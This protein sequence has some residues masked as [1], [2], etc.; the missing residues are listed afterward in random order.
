MK[1]TLLMVVAL[2]FVVTCFAQAA[3]ITFFGEDLNG[4]NFNSQIAHDNF[5]A[6]LSGVGTED[7]EG[8][9]SGTVN[10]TLDFGV[11][12]TATLGGDGY[13]ASGANSVGRFPVSG[14]QYWETGGTFSIAFSTAISA[15]GF[16]ATD[17]GDFNGQVVLEYA[18]GTFSD[19]I[20]I[21]NTLNSPNG[22]L[23]YFGFYEDA[24]ANAFTSINFT[25]TNV[26]TDYFGFDDMTIGTYEQ[27]IIDPVPEPSTI[28]LLGAGLLGLVGYNRK[29]FGKK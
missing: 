5:M 26:G 3:P 7:F 17:I 1:K 21:G 16:Y 28:L 15:F 14:N 4:I 20:N 27:V 11:A 24:I 23:L 10:P 8:F 12:G 25:N 19:S 2:F 29:R 22:S 6:V 9:T 13:V 18:N